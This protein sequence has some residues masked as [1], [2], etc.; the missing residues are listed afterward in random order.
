MMCHDWHMSHVK[1]MMCHDWQRSQI[2]DVLRVPV[3][4]VLLWVFKNSVYYQKS[5]LPCYLK[6]LELSIGNLCKNRIEAPPFWGYVETCRNLCSIWVTC[7]YPCN[8]FNE[9]YLLNIISRTPFFRCCT[10]MLHQSVHKDM[11]FLSE[12][13]NNLHIKGQV[14]WQL[15]ARNVST[16]KVERISP[17]RSSVQPGI[18]SISIIE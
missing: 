10:C 17:V 12:I 3:K 6:V 15:H 14:A 8:D 13:V 9:T 18:S 5:A 2:S 1:I 11:Q 16:F 4:M 7:R